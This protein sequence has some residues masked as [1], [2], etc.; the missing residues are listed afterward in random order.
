MTPEETLRV[1]EL[2]TE[3]ALTFGAWLIKKKY[4]L[5]YSK[6]LKKELYIN[7]S[8]HDVLINGSDYHYTKL[9]EQEGK[10]LQ[11]VYD[12]FMYEE[13]NYI[14][15]PCTNCYGKGCEIC[16][17]NGILKMSGVLKPRT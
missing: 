10:I 3:S 9:I 14:I 7:A 12:K 1:K 4:I 11:E 2:I 5:I 15:I 16:K 13:Y 17:N 6:E 8:E